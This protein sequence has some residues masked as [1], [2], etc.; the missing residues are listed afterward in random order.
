MF[1]FKKNQILL[2]RLQ[3]YLKV[4]QET[5]DQFVEAMEYMMKKGIDEHF[6]LLARQT[7]TKESNADDIRRKIEQEMY[8][9]SLL[10]ESRRDL[11]E[12]VE[13]LDRLPNRA[14]SILNMF[15]TQK[16][17]LLD[18]IKPDMVEL[19]KLSQET[20]KFTLEATMDCLNIKGKMKEYSRLIDNNES[21]G[22]RLERKMITTI[23]EADIDTGEKLLQKE[24]VL[25]IGAIC[26][27]CERLKDKLVIT[28]IKRSI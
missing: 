6:D 16:T 27:L 2:D 23:F 1:I 11:L 18:Q 17:K 21:I 8:A 14:E 7:H 22:D 25:Q 24:F 20:V 19:I 28:S 3:D 10:P 4:N 15:L 12:I 13:Q 26:D 9:K 5:I